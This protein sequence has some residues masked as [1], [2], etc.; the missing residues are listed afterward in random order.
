MSDT[1]CDAFNLATGGRWLMTSSDQ[2]LRLFTATVTGLGMPGID[3][4]FMDGPRAGSDNMLFIA[5]DTLNYDLL[6]FTFVV[7][8]QFKNY[9]SLFDKLHTIV[10]TSIPPYE[11]LDITLLNNMGMDMKVGFRFVDATVFQLGGFQLITNEEGEK[12][13][14]CTASFKFQRIEKL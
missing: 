13:L 3:I 2:N 5:G 10:K 4:G 11:D 9:F 6:N 12:Y 8:S 1:L 7:D 14:V